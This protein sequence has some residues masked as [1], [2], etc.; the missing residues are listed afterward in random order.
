M[1]N[2]ETLQC[3]CNWFVGHGDRGRL[4]W[5]PNTRIAAAMEMAFYRAYEAIEPT[6]KTFYLSVDVSRSMFQPVQ[7]VTR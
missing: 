6:G 5:T 2:C 4:D 3:V 1:S 7:G